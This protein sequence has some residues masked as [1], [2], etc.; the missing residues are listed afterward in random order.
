MPIA[1][2]YKANFETL[3]TA[4][5][6]GDSVLVECTRAS[7]DSSVVLICAINKDESGDNLILPF[8]EM[9]DG[10]PFEVYNPPTASDEVTKENWL[11]HGKH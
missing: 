4:V 5:I 11:N 6:Q 10:N 3:K 2:G 8:A 1:E 9:C 7:D